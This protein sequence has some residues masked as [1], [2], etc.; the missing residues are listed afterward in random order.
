MNVLAVAIGGMIGALLRLWIGILLFNPEAAFPYPTLIINLMGSFFLGWF[1]IHGA[2]MVRNK[3]CILGIQTGIIASFTTFSSFNAE[4]L[5]LMKDERFT[6]ALMYFVIS[7][8]IGIAAILLGMK[9][10]SA[11]LD[12]VGEDL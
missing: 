12:K 5:L 7:T 9:F 1:V 11:T 3:H 4:L 8:V 6:M 10:G 2:K